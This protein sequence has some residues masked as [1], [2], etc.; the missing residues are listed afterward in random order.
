MEGEEDEG[1]TQVLT[2]DGRVRDTTVTAP[3]AVLSAEQL[4][5]AVRGPLVF[6]L[7]LPAIEGPVRVLARPAGQ[8][9]GPPVV[10]VG[11]SIDDRYET[12]SS[13]LTAF[14]VGGPIAVLVAAGLG[15]LLAAAGLAPIEAMRRRA[16]Q[17]SLEHEDERLPLPAARDEVHRLGETL[18][19]MLDRLR[20]S[21]E[22]ER[23]FTADASHELRTPIAVVRTEIEAALA[24]GDYGPAGARG[25]GRR[26]R[27]V[28]PPDAAGR[29]PAGGGPQR[30]R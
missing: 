21:F 10:A 6:E 22:R 7:R 20:R 5:R 3:R 11:Q 17:V 8:R 25:A 15:Y 24:T 9:P 26:P 23:R 12:L 1:F 30:R 28:R 2:A 4:Q 14:A 18:N 19:Q 16:A 29:R 13:L 27:R